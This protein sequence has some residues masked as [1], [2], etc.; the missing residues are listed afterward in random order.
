V[1]TP[2]RS[3]TTIPQSTTIRLAHVLTPAE[4]QFDLTLRANTPKKIDKRTVGMMFL[5]ISWQAVAG[6]PLAVAPSQIPALIFG[7][8][9]SI[10]LLCTLV[11]LISGLGWIIPVVAIGYLMVLTLIALYSP[12][13]VTAMRQL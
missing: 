2:L 5:D 11:F 13:Q 4:P 6:N 7:I 8:P 9:T 12:W 10:V 1:L 3:V